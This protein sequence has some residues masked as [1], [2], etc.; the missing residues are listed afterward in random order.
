PPPPCPAAPARRPL[1]FVHKSSLSKLALATHEEAL[2]PSLAAVQQAIDG[3]VGGIERDVAAAAR[4]YPQHWPPP[5]EEL[6]SVGCDVTRNDGSLLSI[7]CDGSDVAPR[8][9]IHA[10]VFNYRYLGGKLVPLNHG[11]LFPRA[12]GRLTT[13]LQPLCER[14]ETPIRDVA[15]V[16]GV[17]QILGLRAETLLV[18]PVAGDRGFDGI[19]TLPYADLSPLGSCDVL[20]PLVRPASP[21][22]Q[23][24]TEGRPGPLAVALHRDDWPRFERAHVGDA[25]VVAALN[26]DIQAWNDAQRA[27]QAPED[28]RFYPC[29]VTM[30]SARLVSVLCERGAHWTRIV[31]AASFTYRIGET[32]TPVTPE[33]LFAA[34]PG[35][36]RQI[37][38]RCLQQY[39]GGDADSGLTLDA[40]PSWK[41]G[42]LRHFGLAERSVHFVLRFQA[43]GQDGSTHWAQQRCEIPY[44]LLRTSPAL[45]ARQPQS[46]AEAGGSGG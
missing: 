18:Q 38:R 12:Q 27:K 10:R 2:A 22:R 24:A 28:E 42:D 6:V 1:A 14:A 34:R 37:A 41:P 40:L 29:R 35:A 26:R 11:D 30:S 9:N 43:K 32:S 19:C 45:L 33:Q 13:T 15:D 46:G 31:D 4:K 39:L 5:G 21:P 25:A 3:W 8:P 44:D 17:P 23:L 7:F 16:P 20:G 36:A